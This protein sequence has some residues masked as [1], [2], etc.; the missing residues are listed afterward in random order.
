MDCTAKRIRLLPRYLFAEI[1]KKVRIAQEKG[2]DVIKLGI[3]DPDSPTPDYIVKHAE[4][5]ASR[6]TILIRRMRV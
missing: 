2:V 1:D 4:R 5:G 6:K 3:G